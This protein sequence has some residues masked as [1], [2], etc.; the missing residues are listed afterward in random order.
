MSFVA[1]TT[2]QHLWEYDYTI[3]HIAVDRKCWGNLLSR[4]V[5]VIFAE[6]SCVP[7]YAESEPDETV[8]LKAIRDAQQASRAN[9]GTLAAGA[10]SLMTDDG[11]VTLDDEGRFRL[12]VN[13]R[14]VLWTPGGAKKLQ[15]RLMECAH[16]KETGHRGA[17]ATL[18]RRSDTAVGFAWRSTS[19]S[20]S[21]SVSIA[22]ILKRRR[23]CLVRLGRRGCTAPGLA[24][25]STSTLSTLEQVGRWGTMAWV[26]TGFTATFSS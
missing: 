23:R 3:I 11:Q 6:Y 16:M 14:A 8:R 18:Q 15:V 1:K 24:K 21:N 17:V 13:G 20:S 12:L 10:T 19:P 26:K 2:A 25:S 5:P 4:W 7:V 9:L 22:W